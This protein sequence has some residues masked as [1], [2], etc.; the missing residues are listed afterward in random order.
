MAR[1]I[2]NFAVSSNSI[3]RRFVLRQAL[4]NY[5]H[6]VKFVES[7]RPHQLVLLIFLPP[8]FLVLD[9]NAI[10]FPHLSRTRKFAL[11]FFYFV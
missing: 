8:S 9:S 10:V 2:I 1:Y 5:F 3:S 4:A 7:I 6:S 11:I